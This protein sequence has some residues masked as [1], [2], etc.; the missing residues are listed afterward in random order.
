MGDFPEGEQ[1]KADNVIDPERESD[2]EIQVFLIE[3]RLQTCVA[4]HGPEL[5]DGIL[6]Y[7]H[8]YP[9]DVSQ[10]YGLP[11]GFLQLFDIDDVFVY[12]RVS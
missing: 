5:F 3:V 2:E 1:L 9:F 4:I 12:C 7:E 11:E 8:I 6:R 10:L